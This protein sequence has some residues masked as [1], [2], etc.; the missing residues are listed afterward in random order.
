MEIIN[1]LNLFKNN[2]KK[3]KLYHSISEN[4]CIHPSSSIKSN[5]CDNCGAIIIDKVS[6]SIKLILLFILLDDSGKA[7]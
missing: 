3:M 1:N 2:S 4:P 6:K 7:L 5:F